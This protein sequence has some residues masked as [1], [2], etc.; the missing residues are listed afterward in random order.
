MFYFIYYE[1]DF[2]LVDKEFIFYRRIIFDCIN[3]PLFIHPLDSCR[4]IPLFDL[5]AGTAC[6]H[7][8]ES[9]ICAQPGQYIYIARLIEVSS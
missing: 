1:D 4:L 6:V 8:A 9:M 3:I 7:M 5:T 2:R